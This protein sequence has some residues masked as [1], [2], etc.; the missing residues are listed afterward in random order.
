MESGLKGSTS[1][2][3][4]THILGAI[5]IASD[6][7]PWARNE[8]EIAHYAKRVVSLIANMLPIYH[9]HLPLSMHVARY[10]KD[11]TVIVPEHNDGKEQ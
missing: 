8:I 1:Y 7:F 5:L 11:G 4:C 9:G 10:L 2:L 3:S 6:L